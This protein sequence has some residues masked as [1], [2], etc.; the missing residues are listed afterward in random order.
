MSVIPFQPVGPVV[1]VVPHP[2]QPLSTASGIQLA[3]V[4][5]DAETSGTIIA[6]GSAFY[7]EACGQTRPTPYAVGQRVLFGRGAGQEIDG[8]PFGLIGER[9]LLIQESELLAVLEEDA[10]CEVVES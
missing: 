3:D 8:Q 1:V 6:V 2:N 10:V 4:Y 7:C 9:F 5:H